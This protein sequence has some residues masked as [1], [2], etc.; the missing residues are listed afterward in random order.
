[1]PVR[2]RQLQ[3]THDTRAH[4]RPTI[5][6]TLVSSI[7]LYGIVVQNAHG[8]L[9]KR[10]TTSSSRPSPRLLPDAGP[11]S[12]PIQAFH[13]PSPKLFL[14]QHCIGIFVAQWDSWSRTVGCHVCKLLSMQGLIVQS[15]QNV[16][17][18]RRMLHV[19]ITTVSLRIPEYGRLIAICSKRARS[20]TTRSWIEER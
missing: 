17:S 19:S 9:A 2:A 16:A 13:R 10:Y 5:A 7:D 3:P 1:M 8:H 20:A 15:L 4:D 14:V 18:H 12:T 11:L 6:H